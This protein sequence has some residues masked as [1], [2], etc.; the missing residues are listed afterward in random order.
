[1]L[2]VAF[3][4]TTHIRGF[5]FPSILKNGEKRGNRIGQSRRQNK[6]KTTWKPSNNDRVCSDNCVDGESTVTYSFPELKLGYEKAAEK[7]ASQAP[8]SA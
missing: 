5:K 1:M 2:I 6:G 7:R 4:F 3:V 8:R